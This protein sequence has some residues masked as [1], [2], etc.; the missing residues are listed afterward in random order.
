MHAGI[1]IRCLNQ[2]GDSPTQVDGLHHPPI[3]VASKR[4][5]APISFSVCPTPEWMSSQIVALANL[6]ARGARKQFRVLRFLLHS[7]EHRTSGAGHPGLK[8]SSAEPI[9]GFGD[10]GTEP[11]GNRLQVVVAEIEN[12]LAEA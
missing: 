12:F 5:G 1:K 2:L 9:D 6:P 10:R 3:Y 8:S 11:L 4:L 7:G